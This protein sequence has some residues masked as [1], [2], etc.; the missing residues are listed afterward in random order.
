MVTHRHALSQVWGPAHGEDTQYLRVVIAQ[1]RT[2]L[3]AD[4]KAPKH[5]ISEAG[6]G[7]RLVE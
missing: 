2:K 4:P 3:E 7:Y 5:L 6:V 1:L